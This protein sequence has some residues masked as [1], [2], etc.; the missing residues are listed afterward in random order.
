MNVHRFD[1]EDHFVGKSVETIFGAIASKK[2]IVRIALSGGSTPQPIYTALG[3]EKIDFE[4]VH[5]YVLDERYVPMD[6]PDSNAGMIART[7]FA[8]GPL[9]ETFVCF[10][11]AKDI[12][13][14]VDG[15]S[16]RMPADHF[17]LMVLGA[18]P[19][20]HIASLFPY[21]EKVYRSG[22]VAHTQTDR[23]A[24]KDRLTMTLTPIMDAKNVLLILKGA[25]KQGV[26]DMMH[27]EKIRDED[28]PARYLRAHPGLV[29]HCLNC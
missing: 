4:R 7:L 23:F 24:V 21:A 16:S 14:C 15:F 9:P 10:D 27:D 19:D 28:F 17:D 5:F 12:R 26:I 25:A 8:S 1:S 18:G 29:I 6:H 13:M 3:K 22:H 2:G 11:T 20:G